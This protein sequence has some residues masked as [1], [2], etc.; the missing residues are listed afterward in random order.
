MSIQAIDWAI[1]FD[2]ENATEKAVLFMLANYADGDGNCFPGQQN[3][4]KQAACSERSVRRVLDSL[5]ERGIIS[6]EERRRRDGSRTSD[7]IVLAAFVQAANLA[8]SQS[9]TGQPVKTNRPICHNQPATVTGL[10]SFEPS[11]D[12]AAARDSSSEV[13]D[14]LF[15]AV[16]DKMHPHGGIVIGPILELIANGVDLETDILPVVRARAERM[17]RPVRSWA[18]FVDAIKD[19][20]SQR[21][22]AGKGLAKPKV[23]QIK[24]EEDMTEDE[25]RVR[26]GKFLNMARGSSIWLTWLNGPPPG[27]PGCRIPADM[28]EPRDL[29]IDWFEEREQAA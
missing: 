4:A 26:M 9:A 12:T 3:I 27:R 8:G 20:H 15:E 17:T 18:Y 1:S 24:R 23:S 21:I 25:R 29:T 6:R 5:E 14:K 13:S 10:T 28:L 16:G 7:A 2:A 11:G 19:A 22:E